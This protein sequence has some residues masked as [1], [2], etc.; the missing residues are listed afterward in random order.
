MKAP[1][2]KANKVMKKKAAMKAMA[3]ETKT[4][5]KILLLQI[6]IL[7]M[8]VL[9]V[10]ARMALSGSRFF[11]D[12]VHITHPLKIYLKTATDIAPF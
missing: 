12:R 7:T 6:I 8:V 3:V 5:M 4:V 1:A 11:L 2:K 9:L 10:K